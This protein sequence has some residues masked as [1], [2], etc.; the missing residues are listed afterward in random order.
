MD[1]ILEAFIA[2]KEC[3]TQFSNLQVGGNLKCACILDNGGNIPM[4]GAF[5][6]KTEYK[7]L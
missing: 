3:P 4:E 7:T 1:G 2:C 5:V 6:S